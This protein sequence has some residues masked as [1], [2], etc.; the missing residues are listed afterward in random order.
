MQSPEFQVK[1]LGIIMETPLMQY[2]DFPLPEY[3]EDPD[4]S[5]MCRII[6]NTC[7][8]LNL[9]ITY[10]ILKDAVLIHTKK[11]GV[12]I[13]KKLALIYQQMQ[14]PL[15]VV[16]RRYIEGQIKE[17]SRNKAVE[18]A[19]M[20]SVEL[21]HAGKIDDIG[22]AINQ[23][24]AVGQGVIDTGIDPIRDVES[25][26]SQEANVFRPIR[27]LIADL[28]AHLP[29]G[30]LC[31]GDLG[32]VLALSGVGKTMFLISCAKAAVLQNKK[33]VYYTLEMSEADIAERVIASFSG[34]LLTD[35]Y[36]Q[37]ANVISKMK[38][39][40]C[41]FSEKMIIKHFPAQSAGVK[42]LDTHLRLL[43]THLE[44]R[45]N[46]IVVD[47][48]GE[49]AGVSLRKAVGSSE[50]YYELGGI[51][52]ELTG[53]AQEKAMSLWT[54]A[55]V[56]RSKVP[57]E[58]ITIEDIAESFRGVF[59]ASTVVSLNQNATEYENQQMRLFLAK[60]R[61]GVAKRIIPVHTN[62]SKGA[63]Y[64]KVVEDDGEED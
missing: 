52:S 39:L 46:L 45:P 55:Q 20:R 19:L 27:T 40:G 37:K 25:I 2:G 57:R 43:H 38:D 28:D 14:A 53:L 11:N 50:R 9:P 36:D 62:F 29:H 10:S 48:A 58:L 32:V 7:S 64:R 12:D 59:T 3:F 44:F 8:D 61:K 54:G 51:F 5:T 31:L 16:E 21:F 13:G 34:T 18:L 17:V 1:A 47:Y 49:M 60:N 30:G 56:G 15:S 33:V 24:M 4:A 22:V 63:F 23:A 35:L 41:L 26:L 42:T 6:R